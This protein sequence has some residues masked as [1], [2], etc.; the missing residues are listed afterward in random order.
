MNNTGDPYLIT[1][2][3]IHDAIRPIQDLS[4]GIIANFRDHSPNIRE[5]L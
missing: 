4:A 3:S 5:L 2:N 1:L